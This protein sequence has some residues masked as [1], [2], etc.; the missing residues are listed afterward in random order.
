MC[1]SPN[2][3]MD[4]KQLFWYMRHSLPHMDMASGFLLLFLTSLAF[5]LIIATVV[6]HKCMCVCVPM[7]YL[8][9]V[10]CSCVVV[11]V[12]LILILLFLLL[13]V[14]IMPVSSHKDQLKSTERAQQSITLTRQV[15]ILIIII[16]TY[17][18]TCNY[19]RTQW[20]SF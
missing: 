12:V 1:L 20:H 3:W 15:D 10:S 6:M 4:F 8:N 17:I 11:V 19:T 14:W 7:S 16:Y 18:Q 2:A 5:T 13:V 9:K